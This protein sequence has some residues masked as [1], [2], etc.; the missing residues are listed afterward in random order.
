MEPTQRIFRLTCYVRAFSK[1]VEDFDG[2]QK[3]SY[4]TL[5]VCLIPER[6]DEFFRFYH[7]WVPENPDESP[8]TA[9]EIPNPFSP[10]AKVAIRCG[11]DLNNTLGGFDGPYLFVMSKGMA[12]YLASK[13]DGQRIVVKVLPEADE[14]LADHSYDG[15]GNY[16]LIPGQELHPYANKNRD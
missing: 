9:V 10:Y 8:E 6:N 3:V 7:A 11:G 5:M 16:D 15:E 12:Q 4:N 1:L 13:K 2:K 14:A